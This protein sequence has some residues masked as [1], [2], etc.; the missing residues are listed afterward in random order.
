M[1]YAT[2][3][4]LAETEA[5]GLYLVAEARHDPADPLPFHVE[6]FTWSSVPRTLRRDGFGR[7]RIGGQ[8]VYAVDPRTGER[9]PDLDDAELDTEALRD[10][11]LT[12][13]LSHFDK[14]EARGVGDPSGARTLPLGARP[15]RVPTP[16]P[17]V[18]L[19]RAELEGNPAGVD[20]A[21]LADRRRDRERTTAQNRPRPPRGPGR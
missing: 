7:V 10:R 8:W 9:R 20:L 14:I 21:G 12:A 11:I 18:E 19:V 17:V 16:R 15:T 1:A 5:G 13:V 2:I 3:V 6:D 4:E